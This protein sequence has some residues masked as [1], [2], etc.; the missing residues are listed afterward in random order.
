M[1]RFIVWRILQF[2][3]I[4]AIIYVGTF[5]LCWVAPGD[6]FQRT[7]RPLAPQVADS[8]RREYHAETWY[9]FLFYYPTRMLRGDFGPSFNFPGRSV[10]Q[11]IRD[12]FPVSATVGLLAMLIAVAV[13]TF[14]GTIAAVYRGRPP[15]WLSLTV[16]LLGVSLPSFVVAALLRAIF[17]FKWNV[18]PV[19]T[20][21]WSPK[22]MILPA[23]ALSLLPMAYIARL[24]RVSMIDTL[25]SDYIRTARAKGVSKIKV[26]FKHALRNA[27]LPVLSYVGPATAVT[28][29]GSFV[30]ETVFQL[31]G[32]GDFF[33][34]SVGA[35]DQTMVLGVVMVYSSM[36]LALNLV[37]D[38]G[39]TLVDP[40]ISVE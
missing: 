16:A 3:L 27:I 5:L 17:A 39:Y 37:V 11:I 9:G 20:W 18:F 24:T 22:E 10:S 30:V 40:R 2:P 25:S 8:L 23:A 28:M 4:L 19:G 6:P 26:I 34:K 1:L 32:M 35:R 13:G 21:T 38:I 36:L 31:P 33:V 14:I 15:D 7:E 12:T 29:T